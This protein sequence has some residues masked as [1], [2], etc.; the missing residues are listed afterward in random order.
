[1]LVMDQTCHLEK[2]A[3]NDIK[4]MVK[5]ASEGSLKSIWGYTE[6]HV[7]SCSCNSG[8]Q[9]PTFNA[10]VGIT[11]NNHPLISCYDSELGYSNSVAGLMV[12]MASEE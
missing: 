3:K 8:T 2:A 10:R 4:K 1:M 7:I 12:H 5:Q 9:S 11:L 6:D